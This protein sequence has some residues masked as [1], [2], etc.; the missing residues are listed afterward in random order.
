M[1]AWVKKYLTGRLILHPRAERSISKAEYED[2]PMI[3]QALL[4]LAN[5]Y[6]DSR[7]GKAPDAPFREALKKYR[8]D[9]SGSIAEANAKAAGDEYFVNYPIG[10]QNKELLKFHI[11]RGN[12][13]E[14]RFCMR[15]YYFWDAD[16]SQ[17]VVGYLPDH[18]SNRAS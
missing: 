10:T 17:I 2:I 6:R 16:T 9:F 8:M 5:E 12:S 4:I 14:K 7:L 18:L 11:E 15:I 3:Y 1:A 13:R